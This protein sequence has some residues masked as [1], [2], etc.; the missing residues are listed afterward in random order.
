[1]RALPASYKITGKDADSVICRN[2]FLEAWYTKAV[3]VLKLCS[4][5]GI[6]TLQSH[7]VSDDVALYHAD[8][9]VSVQST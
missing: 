4:G 1:M 8:C 9:T 2:H 6:S 5:T 3:S 7:V